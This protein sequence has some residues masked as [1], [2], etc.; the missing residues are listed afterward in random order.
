MSFRKNH[1]FKYKARIVYIFFQ[2]FIPAL[3]S[4]WRQYLAA[5]KKMFVMIK[6]WEA[7]VQNV[8]RVVGLSTLIWLHTIV[9]SVQTYYS[10]IGHDNRA[11]KS[12]LGYISNISGKKFRPL[13]VNN[14]QPS[15]IQHYFTCIF[16]N[17]VWASGN[18]KIGLFKVLWML[19]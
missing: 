13:K 14:C 6:R 17:Q 16:S 11:K 5:P 1:Y 7:F 12:L 18:T 8:K 2:Q 3:L 9:V 19:R 4:Y 15:F 10:P